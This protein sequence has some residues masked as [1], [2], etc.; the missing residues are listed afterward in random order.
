MKRSLSRILS[1]SLALLMAM[2][3]FPYEVVGMTADTGETE[4]AVLPEWEESAEEVQTEYDRDA[5]I[6]FEDTAQRDETTKVFRMSD[7]SYTAAVYPTQVH[8]EENGE[9][10]EIDNQF[11][12]ITDESGESYYQNTA[13]PVRVTMPAGL[14][15][16]NSVTYSRDGYSVSFSLKEMKLSGGIAK[17][18]PDKTNKLK[19]LRNSVESADTD[20]ESYNTKVELLNDAEQTVEGISGNVIYSNVFDGIDLRYIMSGTSL[21]E[22]IILNSSDVTVKSYEFTLGLEGMS[23][24][25]CED[26]SVSMSNSDGEEIFRINAPY[27]YDAIGAE[28]DDIKVT[29]KEG[30]DGTYTYK[31]KPDKKWL[32]S[33]ERVYPVVIDPPVTESNINTVKDTT[34]IYADNSYG[35]NDSDEVC[36]LKV[37]K[38]NSENYKELQAMLYNPLPDVLKSGSTR[39]INAQLNVYKNGGYLLQNLQINAHRITWDWNTVDI[40]ENSVYQ[41]GSVSERNH[42]TDILDYVVIDDTSVSTVTFDITEAAQQWLDGISPNY[43]IALRASGLT[44]TINY[45][46]FADSTVNSN[47]TC[48]KFIYNYRDS[49]GVEDYWSFT[50]LSAGRSGS[51]SVNNFNGNL[52]MTQSLVSGCGNIMPVS[53]SLIRSENS[54]YL[55]K[56]SSPNYSAASEETYDS[57]FG[58]WRTNYHIYIEELNSTDYGTAYPYCFIDADSTRHYIKQEGSE[59]KDEDGYGWTLKKLNTEYKY[60]LTDKDKTKYYF[61]TNGRLVRIIDSNGNYNN[62]KYVTETANTKDDRIDYIEEGGNNYPAARAVDFTYSGAAVSVTSNNDGL[63]TVGLVSSAN[64]QVQAIYYEDY[65]SGAA[66]DHATRFKTVQNSDGSNNLHIY[67]GMGNQ[68]T[69]R[70]VKA[71]GIT[72]ATAI[73]SGSGHNNANDFSILDQYTFVYAHNST[74]ITDSAGRA[75]S[76]QFNNYGQT[77]GVVDHTTSVGQK[78]NYAPQN[79]E[80][81]GQEN[82]LL[83]SSKAIAPASNRLNYSSFNSAAD[84]DHY[85]VYP[86][87][88]VIDKAIYYSYGNTGTN[89]MQLGKT[90]AETQ[91]VFVYQKVSGLTQGNYTLSFYASTKGVKLGGNGIRAQI[92]VFDSNGYRTGKLSRYLTYTEDGE[93]VRLQTDIAIVSGDTSVNVGISLDSTMTGTVCI[94]D[95]QFEHNTAGGASLSNVS[96]A[97]SYNLLKNSYFYQSALDGWT[98]TG[99]GGAY[100]DTGDPSAVINK[101]SVTGKVDRSYTLKQTVYVDGAK[102]DSFIAGCWVKADS[103]PLTENSHKPVV[104]KA[105]LYVTFYNDGTEVGETISEDINT[106]TE[107]WQYLLLKASAPGAYDQVT[108]FFSYSYNAGSASIAT[109]FLY[110]ETYGQSYTYDDNGNLVSSTDAADSRANFAYQDNKLSAAISPTG[111]RYTY[112][113]NSVTGDNVYALSNAGQRIDNT[114]NDNGNVTSMRI[115]DEKSVSSAELSQNTSPRYIVNAKT[116]R[117]LSLDDSASPSSGIEVFTRNHYRVDIQKWW[118]YVFNSDA[119]IYSLRTNGNQAYALKTHSATQQTL[120][121]IAFGATYPENTRYKFVADADGSF[122]ILT[123][124]SGFTKC[125]YDSDVEHTSMDGSFHVYSDGVYDDVREDGGQEYRWLVLSTGTSKK[126]GA[127][128]EYT[129]NGKFLI[130]STDQS[131]YETQYSYHNS[132]MV[133]HEI[134]PKGNTVNYEY[135]NMNNITSVSTVLDNNGTY[136]DTAEVEYTYVDGL[137][138]AIRSGGDNGVMYSFDYDKYGRTTDVKVGTQSLVQNTYTG[139]L[140]TTQTYG[141]G[142]ALNYTYDGLD[143]VIQKKY[144]DTEGAVHYYYDPNGNLYKV[145]DSVAGTVTSTDYDLANR[146][147]SVTLSSS[148]NTKI[149]AYQGI[150]Y[151]DQKGTVKY[152]HTA[153]FDESNSLYRNTTYRYTYGDPALGEMPDVLYKM[154]VGGNRFDYSYDELGRLTKRDLNT[155][156]PVY[157]E[158]SYKSAAYRSGFTTTLV[159]THR[160][161]KGTTHTYTYDAVGNISSEQTGD[162]TKRYFYDD[163]NRLVRADDPTVGRSYKYDYDNRGNL[164]RYYTYAYTTGNLGEVQSVNT[165]T[166]GNNNWKDQLTSYKVGDTAYQIEYDAAGNPTKWAGGKLFSWTNGRRLSYVTV[167]G[168][169]NYTYKYDSDGLRTAKLNGADTQYYILNGRYV[170]E[171]TVVDGRTF[172]IS[173]L[174]DENGSPIGITVNRSPYYFIKNIQGDVI[175]IVNLSG[176]VVANYTY[177]AWGKPLSVY[178]NNGDITGATQVANLNPFRYRGYMYDQETGLYYLGSRYYDPAVGR[179][180]NG[181]IPETLT[182]EFENFAQYNLFAYCFNN[183]INMSD[184]TGTWPSLSSLTKKIAIGVGAVLVGAAVVAAT[185]ATGGAAAAFVGAAVAGLKA[186]AVSGAI[187]AAVGAGTSAVSHRISTG[188]WEGA[189][190]AAVNGAVNGFADGFMTGGITAGAGMTVGALGKTSSGIQIGKTAKPQ[191]G[192]VNAGYGTPKTN[193]NTLISIQN[194]AGKRIFSLD[195]DSIHSVHMHLPK[196]LPGK[197]IPIGAICSGIYAGGRQW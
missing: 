93:W 37:G 120:T 17:I 112:G 157:E 113:Y 131:G 88:A 85:T 68:A 95:I 61:D 1:F 62:I 51:I 23:A 129:D 35:L 3:V 79:T 36:E 114:Y 56:Y 86:T 167:P 181:D 173:Y 48:P 89:C 47:A 96:G 146:V 24:V 83:M 21:K 52:V 92:N 195:L 84:V 128:S 162:Y 147:A 77:A 104:P 58:D 165:Y 97:G 132:G 151:N 13:S 31:L 152:N 73:A 161:F 18:N 134:D 183:P 54:S 99:F 80:N 75:Y 91:S 190:K 41:I 155:T 53:V 110:K 164:L 59:Y 143:R 145:S 138:D 82:K 28:S 182:A 102:G 22:E 158:Y 148:D 159:D 11:E 163:L 49:R 34:G 4:D 193:G 184:E 63:A 117:A 14:S 106:G 50:S 43:G 2:Y 115:T 42:D 137:L 166:Y 60:Q 178:G 127:D 55:N 76:Y 192:K 69:V 142:D 74:K 141:N 65:V 20:D 189:D 30:K 40:D 194:N 156:S 45:V 8:Y 149:L 90:A 38:R 103:V 125:L 101:A 174:Y 179:F 39:I 109:P 175:G 133:A 191:Y 154:Y 139:R 25:L 160:D 111:S 57:G 9:M 176:N 177:D 71:N 78:Y 116:G 168:E 170:G 118:F 150:Q 188:S 26:G 136:V 123:A 16:D 140:L 126:M 153:I 187:G 197:H 12:L 5:Y 44:N 98:A 180:L 119:G 33:D 186:A 172:I 72:R 171:K 87:S 196:L 135:D 46:T 70:R 105:G 122:Y 185:A 64:H 7:G 67:D 130:G 108:Y 144:N 121:Q 19:K 10:V 100:R 29:L 107:D 32:N 94:D 124:E 6:L 66:K 27:M 15:E 81:K 169:G